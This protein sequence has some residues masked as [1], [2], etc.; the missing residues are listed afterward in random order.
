MSEIK[1]SL[2]IAQSKI[3]TINTE[4]QADAMYEY[5]INNQLVLYISA[6]NYT[7]YSSKSGRKITFEKGVFIQKIKYLKGDDGEYYQ[8]IGV[9]ASKE[10][11]DGFGLP[12]RPISVIG[13]KYPFKKEIQ[14]LYDSNLEKI[15]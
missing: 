10:P 7:I 6:N 2:I 4:G 8:L 3:K 14:Y 1:S 9:K 15:E 5:T 11:L 13:R 12:S